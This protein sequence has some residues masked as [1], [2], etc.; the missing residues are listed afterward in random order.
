MRRPY[1][2]AFLTHRGPSALFVWGF[3]CGFV[4]GALV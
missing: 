4:V 3:V 1:L 2:F